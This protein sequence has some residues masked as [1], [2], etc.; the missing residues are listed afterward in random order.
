MDLWWDQSSNEDLLNR[1]DVFDL[2]LGQE[3]WNGHD[4]DY[5]ILE[6]TM[7]TITLH[8]FDLV[9]MDQS[10]EHLFQVSLD[11]WDQRLGFQDRQIHR[12]QKV[13]LEMDVLELE[14]QDRL[15]EACVEDQHEVLL[16]L[17][18]YLH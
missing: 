18:H 12:F 7:G 13:L 10:E 4:Q 3:E 11:L 14:A 9:Q 1:M 16:E 17:L 2:G 8:W 6:K 5:E 15:E